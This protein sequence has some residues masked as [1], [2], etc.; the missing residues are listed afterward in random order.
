METIAI[1]T[2]ALGEAVAHTITALESGKSIEGDKLAQMAFWST[3]DPRL[4]V[5]YKS[6]LALAG[7]RGYQRV[8]IQENLVNETRGIIHRAV[9]WGKYDELHDELLEELAMID[10]WVEALGGIETDV[11]TSAEM[12]RELQAIA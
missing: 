8:E 6:A 7:T 2:Q 10:E 5:W 11:P 1:T 9:I 12:I 3:D 4:S